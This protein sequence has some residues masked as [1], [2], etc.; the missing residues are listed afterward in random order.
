[1]LQLSLRPRLRFLTLPLMLRL[2]LAPS[3]PN[4]SKVLAT[5]VATL[6]PLVWDC[7][8]KGRLS[9]FR[10]VLQEVR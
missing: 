8:I 3:L 9:L 6:Q 10:L 7:N 1:M 4:L 2:L 5:L